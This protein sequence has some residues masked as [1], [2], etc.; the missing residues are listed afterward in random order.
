MTLT[1]TK[2]SLLWQLDINK[3]NKYLCYDN[4]TLNKKL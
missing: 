4:L 1:K 3:D 2:M